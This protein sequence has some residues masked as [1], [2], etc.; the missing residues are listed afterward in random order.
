MH[1]I[2][3]FLRSGKLDAPRIIL[4]ILKTIAKIS[5][6]LVLAW[7]IHA[8]YVQDDAQRFSREHRDVVTSSAASPQFK[9]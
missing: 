6:N 7:R 2:T 8:T 5:Q 9:P 3:M 1:N 4:N